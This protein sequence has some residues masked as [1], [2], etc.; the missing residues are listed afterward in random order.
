MVI[1]IHAAYIRVKVPNLLIASNLR[2]LGGGNPLS[3]VAGRAG[4][5][6]IQIIKITVQLEV[7]RASEM[8]ILT[9]LTKY[10]NIYQENNDILIFIQINI[11]H[12]TIAN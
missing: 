4:S 11:A 8:T 7:V 6:T 1:G 10:S 12:I 9:S 2:K 3:K 5:A